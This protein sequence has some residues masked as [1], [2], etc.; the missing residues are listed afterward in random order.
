MWKQIYARQTL[1]EMEIVQ[2]IDR[3]IKIKRRTVLWNK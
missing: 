3:I 1:L 2:L